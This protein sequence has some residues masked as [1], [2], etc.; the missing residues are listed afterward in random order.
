MHFRD[1]GWMGDTLRAGTRKLLAPAIALAAAASV[2]PL[3]AKDKPARSEKVARK[4]D[5]RA[6]AS[7]NLPHAISP[8]LD[9]VRSSR[10][11]LQGISGY[12]ATLIR[13]EQIRKESKRQ[14]VQMKFRRE[15][16]SVYLHFI[17][18]HP[19]REV[20]YV[21]GQNKNKLLV[22]EPSG[23]V[24]LAG[25]I[26]LSP[27]GDQAMKES[28]YPITMIGMEKLMDALVEQF[29]GE[30]TL[31]ESRLTQ[32]PEA[33]VGS[34][35]CKM[36]EVVRDK[37]RPHVKFQKTR[38]YIDKQS[39]LPIRIEQYAFPAKPGEEGVLAEEYVYTEINTDV[40]LTDRD[41]DVANESYGF[42]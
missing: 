35:E 8:A 20:I 32:Y 28:R 6:A 33:K 31:R 5:D 25:T 29:E 16:F 26:S 39:N 21:D 15:P 13:Q 27:T 9:A 12:S 23:I 18:P 2:L 14:V 1:I 7:S 38:L 34:I 36:Y 3:S 42:K 24:S 11:S 37:E 30:L 4:I 22:H 19:G 17:D 10:E 41:F 40:K